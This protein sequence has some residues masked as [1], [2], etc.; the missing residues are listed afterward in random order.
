MNEDKQDPKSSRPPSPVT[1]SNS[2]ARKDGKPAPKVGSGTADEIRQGLVNQALENVN[3]ALLEHYVAEEFVFGDA[4]ESEDDEDGS[5]PT[6]RAL[7]KLVGLKKPQNQES[8]QSAS[9]QGIK[10]SLLGSNQQRRAHESSPHL[11]G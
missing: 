3:D 9:T 6:P 4:V 5:Q 11:V 1:R 10:N 8:D 2:P 7:D